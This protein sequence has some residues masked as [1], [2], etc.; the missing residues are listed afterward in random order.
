MDDKTTTAEIHDPL[1]VPQ[2]SSRTPT[3]KEM[4]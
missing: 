4:Y 2:Q 1:V 3:M